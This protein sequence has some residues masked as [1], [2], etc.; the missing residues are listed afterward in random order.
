MVTLLSPCTGKR[1]YILAS[2]QYP[3]VPIDIIIQCVYGLDSLLVIKNVC[4]LV[5]WTKVP[6]ALE[7]LTSKICH[8]GIIW[9]VLAEYS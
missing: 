8:V 6:S 3:T 4:V 9:I 2:S 7:G 5:L 1:I